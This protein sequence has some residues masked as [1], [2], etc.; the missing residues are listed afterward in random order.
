MQLHER[1]PFRFLPAITSF[2]LLIPELL[3]HIFLSDFYRHSIT[4]VIVDRV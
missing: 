4:G 2:N 1:S 3:S